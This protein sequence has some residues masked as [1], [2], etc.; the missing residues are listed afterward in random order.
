MF[1]VP[2][3]APL[4]PQVDVAGPDQTG[5]PGAALGAEGAGKACVGPP[6]LP[7]RPGACRPP[8]LP[9]RSSPRRG[10]GVVRD[11]PALPCGAA[12]RS[13][14]CR[15]AGAARSGV[16]AG[17]SCPAQEPG[18]V[19]AQAP[20]WTAGAGAPRAA[21][22]RCGAVLCRGALRAGN[23]CRIREL[24]RWEPAPRKVVARSVAASRPLGYL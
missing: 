13:A 5:R 2:E 20:E 11:S 3:G 22:V 12:S 23:A 21:G 17:R 6:P 4:G 10:A 19:P 15:R 9:C 18:A 24:P 7:P 16:S 1:G 8:G 14:E